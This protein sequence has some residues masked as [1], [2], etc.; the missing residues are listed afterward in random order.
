MTRLLTGTL[1]LLLLAGC[2]PAGAGRPQPDAGPLPPG[3]WTAVAGGRAFAGVLPEDLTVARGTAGAGVV[4]A[5]GERPWDVD[6]EDPPPPPD[7]LAGWPVVDGGLGEPVLFTEREDFPA[8]TGVWQGGLATA[9][10]GDAVYLVELADDTDVD[11]PA[12]GELALVRLDPGTGEVTTT[13][14]PGAFPFGPGA[15]LYGAEL[16]CADDGTCRA[17]LSDGN[18]A[19]AV[20][21]LDLAT[22]AVLENRPVE[23][24]G[25]T[26]T[27][28]GRLLVTIGEDEGWRHDTEG[29]VDSP[30]VR[31]LRPWVEYRTPEGAPAGPRVYLSDGPA[32]T[33]VTTVL[34]DG[35]V[36][37]ALQDE[38]A[39]RAWVVSVAPGVTAATTVA[40]VPG[41]G[42]VSGLLAD[43][44]GGWVHVLTSSDVLV[45]TVVSVERATGAVSVSGPL[46]AGEGSLEA[47]LPTAAGAVA[48]GYCGER[49]EGLWVVR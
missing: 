46:C 24:D 18:G 41:T 42:V 9:P 48:V 49:G 16:T 34:P 22:G 32:E 1:A 2:A 27:A 21:V 31:E 15:I 5:L 4:W 10:D 35:A 26:P 30:P 39:G 38:A 14:L 23:G 17:E 36:L 40:E 44:D 11:S 37:A 43:P 33:Q 7:V 20:L 8:T 25:G 3:P 28:D 13:E 47:L 6:S 12:L 19:R 45:P 29:P